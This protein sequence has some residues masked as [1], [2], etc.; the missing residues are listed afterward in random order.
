MRVYSR[1]LVIF[2]ATA[3][4]ACAGLES[5]EV[6]EIEDIN[7]NRVADRS[8]EFEVLMPIENPSGLRFRIVDVDLDVYIN[9]EYL[10]KIRNVDN[11]LIPSRSSELYTF[12]LKVEFANI[13]RGAVSMFTFFLDR[14]AYIE[15]K[16]E[17]RVRS[18]PFGK[19]I[20]VEEKTILQM[21]RP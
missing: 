20:P 15:V 2:A 11:V 16:G 10:G 7:F 21:D 5:I 8:I 17:I 18:F 12:P 9:D 1:L 13:L 6:G 3:L 14:K 4:F 19:S